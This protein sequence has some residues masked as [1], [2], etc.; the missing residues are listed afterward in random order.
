MKNPMH[1]TGDAPA[2]HFKEDTYDE[3]KHDNG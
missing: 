3:Q 1:A 2:I